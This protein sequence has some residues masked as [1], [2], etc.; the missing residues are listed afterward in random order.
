MRAAPA[1]PTVRYAHLRGSRPTSPPHPTT[2][3]T[4]GEDQIGFCSGV[5]LAKE[6]RPRLINALM[7]GAENV[8]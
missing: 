8:G 4:Q 2:T 3:L 7:A 1:P 6:R 5:L